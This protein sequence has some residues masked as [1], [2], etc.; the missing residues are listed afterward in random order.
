MCNTGRYVKTEI[1]IIY[2]QIYKLINLLLKFQVAMLKLKLIARP[3]SSQF[4]QYC[5]TFAILEFR[6][7]SPQ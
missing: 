7:M 6:N 2:V 4:T 5:I 3:L 1:F